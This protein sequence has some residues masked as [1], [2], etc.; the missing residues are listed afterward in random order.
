MSRILVCCLLLTVFIHPAF[1][2]DQDE[3]T[4]NVPEL[5]RMA[6]QAY[7]TGDQEQYRNLV[8][9]LHQLRPNNSDYMYQLVLAHAALSEREKAFNMMVQC[10]SRDSLT[11]STS[12]RIR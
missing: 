6:S 7:V 3:L 5:R 12:R 8:S 4:D 10:N 1:A 11:I 2:E 9:R